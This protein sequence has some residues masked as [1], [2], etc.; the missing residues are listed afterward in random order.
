VT[1]LTAAAAI[2]AAAIPAAAAPNSAVAQWRGAAAPPITADAVKPILIKEFGI[3][4]CPAVGEGA[5]VTG[6]MGN[7][8]AAKAGLVAGDIIVE[9]N[10]KKVGDAEGLAKLVSAAAPEAEA[11]LKVMRSGRLQKA[12]VM[13]GEGEMEGFT[14]IQKP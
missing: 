6:V 8:Y 5:K 9:C 1:K 4:V 11:Q 3:E 10:G 13:V 2:P 7:S 12:A 14:P